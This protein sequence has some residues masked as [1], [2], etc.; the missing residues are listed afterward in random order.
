M[1]STSTMTTMVSQ[2]I[3]MLCPKITTTMVST[4]PRTMMTMVTE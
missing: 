4:M 2:T 1:T 3:R